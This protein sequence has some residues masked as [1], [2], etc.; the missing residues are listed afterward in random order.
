M[1]KLTIKHV[2]FC[3]EYIKN[4]GNRTKAYKS[5]FNCSKV[6]DKSVNE[7]SSRLLNDKR[8]I[9][10]LEELQKPLQKKFEY[11]VEQALKE[12]DEA[13]EMAEGLKKPEAM[14]SATMGKSQR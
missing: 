5:A 12:L 10:Q 9:E 2:N 13:R 6:T 7:S 3:K 8:I 1:K 11:T 4:G 14:I